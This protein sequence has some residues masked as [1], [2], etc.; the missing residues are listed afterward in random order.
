[1]WAAVYTPPAMR[2]NATPLL[3]FVLSVVS[4]SAS[5]PS[6][7]CGATVRVNLSSDPTKIAIGKDLFELET[8]AQTLAPRAPLD[9]VLVAEGDAHQLPARHF[10]TALDR[11]LRAGFPVRLVESKSPL[12]FS[13]TATVMRGPEE[14]LTQAPK[15]AD[16]C[17]GGDAPQQFAARGLEPLLEVDLRGI[18]ALT[19]KGKALAVESF[20]A[21]LTA[22]PA[23][24]EP[25]PSAT[26]AIAVGEEPTVIDL[27]ITLRELAARGFGRALFLLGAGENDTAGIL[28]S[29]TEGG[30]RA[31]SLPYRKTPLAKNDQ[32][33]YRAMRILVEEALLAMRLEQRADGSFPADD[34]FTDAEVTALA[35]VAFLGAGVRAGDGSQAGSCVLRAQRWL[36]AWPYDNKRHPRRERSLVSACMLEAYART[37]HPLLLKRA[38]EA[39]D[40]IAKELET[41]KEIRD[42]A[43]TGFEAIGLAAARSA[44]VENVDPLIEKVR[45]LIEPTFVPETGELKSNWSTRNSSDYAALANG[46]VL[47]GAV[48]AAD[49]RVVFAAK[50]IGDEL[51]ATDSSLSNIARVYGAFFG[52]RLALN[53]GGKY[54]DDL[55]GMLKRSLPKR[56]PDDARDFEAPDPGEV[57]SPWS[58]GGR[59]QSVGRV[60]LMT[61]VYQ[62][63]DQWLMRGAK[64]KK[65]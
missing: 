52:A 33:A 9:A 15:L 51:P 3:A 7:E 22:N 14:W 10:L 44:R 13:A 16:I 38:L 20:P 28:L 62:V 41:D 30:D 27:V 24:G 2:T 57:T 63:P 50:Q 19:G 25:G 1:M 37:R 54:M 49:P 11:L 42:G 29:L 46:L 56:A 6:A 35:L 5:S 40:E 59:I 45:A 65:G 23:P 39:R 60:A 8:I 58:G 53:G 21:D 18:V 26:V 12:R 48:A 61:M 34:E 31:T 47:F 32:P 43:I 4:W 64:G 17:A 55:I 36:M